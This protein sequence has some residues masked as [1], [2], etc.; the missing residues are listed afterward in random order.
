[1]ADSGVQRALDAIVT[2]ISAL[3]RFAQP[4]VQ[5]E[6]WKPLEYYSDWTDYA[7]ASQIAQYRKDPLGRVWIRAEVQGTPPHPS[8][9]TI[10]ILPVGYRPPYTLKFVVK[11]DTGV[12]S[13]EILSDGRINHL[14][15]AVG[16]ISIHLSFDTE[17]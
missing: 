16:E 5:P 15:G 7:A 6:K 14:D 12:G 11:A 3:V 8:G 1:M 2:T 4:F 13:I 9:D 10:A 17:A